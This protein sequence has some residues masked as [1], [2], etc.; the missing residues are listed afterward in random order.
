MS[1]YVYGVARS[2]HPALPERMDGVGDPPRPVRALREG[3]LAA[4]VSDCPPGLRPERHHLMAH[5][6]VLSTAEAAEVVLPLRFGSVSRDEDTVRHA[7]AEHAEHYLAQLDELEGR[8]EFNVKAAHRQDALLH[9]VITEEPEIHALSSANHAAGG[10]SHQDRLRLGTMIAEA[11]RAREDRDAALVEEALSPC[12]E[13]H[14]PGP[15]NDSSLVNLCF[16]LPREG[17]DALRSAVRTLQERN[18]QLNLR[19]AGPL[20]PYSFVTSPAAAARHAGR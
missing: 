20:P 11:V 17:C 16:L 5:Q 14:C 8:V 12:A 1:V 10:G 4:L 15:E 9:Q 7:L 6:H 2:G 18:P 13:R 19:V 3:P